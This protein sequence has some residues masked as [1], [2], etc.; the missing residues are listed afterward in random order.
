MMLLISSGS[1]V[2]SPYLILILLISTLSFCPLLRFA[3]GLF[4]LLTF[5]KKIASGLVDS[6]CSTVCF[7]L[8]DF[9]PEFDYLLPSTPL[10]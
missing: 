1:A 4:I 5:S 10:W 9:S 7:H 8:V 3:M 6:L 2:M